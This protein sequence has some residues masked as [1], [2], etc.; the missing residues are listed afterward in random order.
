MSY[1][2]AFFRIV[3]PISPVRYTT[4]DEKM[5]PINATGGLY[6]TNHGYRALAARSPQRS[7]EAVLKLLNLSQIN[8][9]GLMAMNC[10]SLPLSPAEVGSSLGK[11][12]IV[13]DLRTCQYHYYDENT[14]PRARATIAKNLSGGPVGTQRYIVFAIESEGLAMLQGEKP[15]IRLQADTEAPSGAKTK[16]VYNADFS[17]SP[18]EDVF[19]YTMIRDGKIVFPKGQLPLMPEEIEPVR[20]RP[21]VHS[22]RVVTDPKQTGLS[23]SRIRTTRHQR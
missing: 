11:R 20:E 7:I 6:E 13:A 22:K 17:V 3:Q 1:Y 5:E 23:G 18:S 21:S 19:E 10:L 12:F 15:E 9:I 14:M 4:L 16:L 2:T 8:N